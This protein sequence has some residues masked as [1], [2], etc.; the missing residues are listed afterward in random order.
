[1][2]SAH[3]FSYATAGSY[4]EEQMRGHANYV[5]GITSSFQNAGGWLADQANKMMN[6]FNNFMDSRAWEMGK[7]MFDS[8]RG[9][10][11]SRFD[12]GYLGSVQGFQNDEGFMRDYIMA[13]PLMQQAYIDGDISGYGGEFNNLCNGIGE[14]NLFYRRAKHGLLNFDKVDDVTRLRHTHYQESL[15]GGLGFRDRVNLESTYRALDYHRAQE[16]I[17]EILSN[18]GGVVRG[19]AV[20]EA[21]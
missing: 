4:T 5:S 21:E 19:K 2:N 9:D 15:G 16:G 11:V 14:D 8:N 1:M 17:F 12:I 13:H 18:P 3:A 6:S 10:Y 7:R 20:D